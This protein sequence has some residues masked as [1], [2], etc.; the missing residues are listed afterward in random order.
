[1][2]LL[3]MF[4][5]MTFQ[6]ESSM[7]TVLIKYTLILKNYLKYGMVVSCF[8]FTTFQEDI[9]HNLHSTLIICN[10][11]FSVVDS[12]L[13]TNQS[14][15]QTLV[16]F[17]SEGALGKTFANLDFEN[18]CSWNWEKHPVPLAFESYHN[19][20]QMCQELCM[21]CTP[22]HTK[23]DIYKCQRADTRS[24]V[25]EAKKGAKVEIFCNYMCNG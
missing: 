9:S 5:C 18:M 23:R 6:L 25:E 19:Q 21:P 11:L 12:S 7:H 14:F 17:T 3:V 22:T 10:A 20:W 16:L 15:P 2:A 1:M 24:R 13:L 8:C 4:K